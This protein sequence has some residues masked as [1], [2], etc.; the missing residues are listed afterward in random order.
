MALFDFARVNENHPTDPRFLELCIFSETG[1]QH[2][3]G[4]TFRILLLGFM[5]TALRSTLL[6]QRLDPDA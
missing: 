5:C 4:R 1:S 2:A 6:L 3:D